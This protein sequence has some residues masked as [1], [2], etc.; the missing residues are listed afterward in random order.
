MVVKRSVLSAFAVL[1]AAA[2]ISCS[3]PGE[4]EF[5]VQVEVIGVVRSMVIGNTL[6]FEG[7]AA[8][9]AG[10]RVDG[11]ITWSVS[12]SA[13]ISVTAE[14]VTVGGNLVNRATV[15]GLSVGAADL[16]A[17]AEGETGQVRVTVNAPPP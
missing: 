12:N 10:T 15:T 5:V 4:P 1:L 11:L 2:S 8:T 17:T 16:I 3:D 7:R 9:N 14:L 13:I 6:Q